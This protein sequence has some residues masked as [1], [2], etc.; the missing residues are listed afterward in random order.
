M[1]KSRSSRRSTSSSLGSAGR[2]WRGVGADALPESPAHDRSEQKNRQ[3]VREIEGHARYDT[4][5]DVE[6]LNQVY[7]LLDLYVNLFWPSPKL[8]AKQRVGSRVRKVCDQA[9]IPFERLG[10]AGVLAPET[11][12]RTPNRRSE[13]ADAPPGSRR[14]HKPPDP[15]RHAPVPYFARRTNQSAAIQPRV[16]F[17]LTQGLRLCQMTRAKTAAR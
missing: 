2:L 11:E 8:T 6:W 4:L 9:R 14:G 5:E 3:L 7:R 1:G 12:A 13:S 10:S 15:L 17:P 16:V